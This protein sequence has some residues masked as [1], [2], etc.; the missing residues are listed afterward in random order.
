MP[1]DTQRQLYQPH[2]ARKFDLEFTRSTML[3]ALAI[4]LAIILLAM[5]FVLGAI[6][7]LAY[8]NRHRGF[9]YFASGAGAVPTRAQSASQ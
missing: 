9:S 1:R 3:H 5:F 6:F 8:R 7:A 2:K 4:V